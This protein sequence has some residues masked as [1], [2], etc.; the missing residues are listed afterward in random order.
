M[1]FFRRGS[2]DEPEQPDDEDVPEASEAQSLP[3]EEASAEDASSEPP[4]G[5][6]ESLLPGEPPE[7]DLI[8]EEWKQGSPG[9]SDS[10][11]PGG[12]SG[13]GSSPGLGSTGASRSSS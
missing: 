2:S 7:P 11:M 3:G 9:K 4:P 8:G 5:M 12:V 1:R 10:T 6:V 13:A